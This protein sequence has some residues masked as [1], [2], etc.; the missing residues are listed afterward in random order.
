MII[1]DRL[2]ALRE[3]MKL[4][5]TRPPHPP[6]DIEKRNGFLRCYIIAVENGHIRSRIETRRNGWRLEV[7][8]YQ[9]LT[10]ARNSSKGRICS[11][12]VI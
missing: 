3:E 12:E 5:Q 8:L 4:S 7:P 10:T 6:R 2:R 11:E 9:L 1:G